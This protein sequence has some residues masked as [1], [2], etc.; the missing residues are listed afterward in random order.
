MPNMI[1]APDIMAMATAQLTNIGSAISQAQ[2]DVLARTTALPSAAADEVS[3]AAALLFDGYAQRYHMLLDH[4]EAFHDVFVQALA[5][6]AAAYTHTEATNTAGLAPDDLSSTS[7][8]RTALIMGYTGIATPFPR[9]LTNIQNS[10]IRRFFPDA[11]PMGV[12]TPEQFWPVT[13]NLGNH[14]TFDQSVS[15]GVT[16]LDAAIRQQLTAGHDTVV[17]GYSQ[18][19]TV[20]TAEIIA[21]SA[22]PVDLR[23]DP[24]QLTFILT[25]NPN[26]PNGG[27][28]TRFPDFYLPFLNVHFSGAT[29]ADSP[30]PTYIYTAQYDGIAH[31]PQYPLNVVSDLNA[32]MGYFTVHNTHPFL[33]PEQVAHAELLPT[34]PGYTGNTQYYML[35]T[36]DL[37]LLAPIRA[38]PFAGRPLADLIQPSLRVIVDLGYGSL[39]PG[40][41]YADIAT[42]ASFVQQINLQAVHDALT[43]GAVQGQQAALVDLGLLPPSALPTSY[44]YLPSTNPGLSY[45][46]GQSPRTALSQLSGQLG[47]IL[48]YIPTFA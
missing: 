28:L 36:H 26:N 31:T 7:D 35:L 30:Y 32:F 9:Y 20:A 47:S 8:Q 18:S 21:L 43:L 37:P 34:S 16:Q 27:L 14:L 39:G 25:G 12:F 29:P 42:P 11:Q 6:A 46:S 17:F 45:S 3:A 13:P 33:T 40:Y 22:L 41:D 23:P 38:I 44:P 19:S 1:A 2:V 5:A 48:S 10:Y 4:V 15:I 24:S